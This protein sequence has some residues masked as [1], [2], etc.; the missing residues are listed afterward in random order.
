MTRLEILKRR[1]VACNTKTNQGG[2]FAATWFRLHH[3]I[4]NE[5]Q[6]IEERAF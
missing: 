2:R 5:I 6:D 3:Y 1:A 4:L